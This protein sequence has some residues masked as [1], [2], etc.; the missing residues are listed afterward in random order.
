MAEINVGDRITV[1]LQATDKDGKLVNPARLQ[2]AYKDPD[3]LPASGDK[4]NL[5]SPYVYGIDEELVRD[6]T[7][8]FHIDL[9]IDK[10]GLWKYRAIALDA[11]GKPWGATEG[12]FFVNSSEF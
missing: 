10:A 6:A 7:G 1:S 3:L 5:D 4:G 11:E 8:K 9:P 12:S 2:F